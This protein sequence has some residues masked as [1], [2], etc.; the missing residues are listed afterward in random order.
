MWT[1]AIDLLKHLKFRPFHNTGLSDKDDAGP[2]H[3]FG[4]GGGSQSSDGDDS[5]EEREAAIAAAVA[6][7][8]RNAGGSATAAMAALQ[9]AEAAL[10]GGT[11][12]K[13]GFLL[14][15]LYCFCEKGRLRRSPG[16]LCHDCDDG[17]A[18][19]GRGARWRRQTQA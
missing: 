11:K 16:G 19:C 3:G 2:S 4:G 1:H 13:G 10:D 8:A 17:A 9:R 18:A 14:G 5:E 12:L 15:T 7:R 6:R